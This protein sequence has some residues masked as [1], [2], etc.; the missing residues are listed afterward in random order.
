MNLARE[1]AALKRERARVRGEA[2][3]LIRHLVEVRQTL[4]TRLSSPSA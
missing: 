4:A 3:T 1:N 2:E